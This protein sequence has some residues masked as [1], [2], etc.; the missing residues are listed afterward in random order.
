MFNK[1]T[2]QQKALK[3]EAPADV[4]AALQLPKGTTIGVVFFHLLE[5]RGT[6]QPIT[7]ASND[8]RLRS[9][10]EQAKVYLTPEDRTYLE[11]AGLL[12]RMQGFERWTEAQTR[13]NTRVAGD[14]RAKLFEGIPSG[15]AL[16]LYAP[17]E[18]LAAA[19]ERLEGT[20]GISER[21]RDAVS[22][23]AGAME[24]ERKKLN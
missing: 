15:N 12:A 6:D 1:Q 10:L 17:G 21:V 18:L 7:V 5:Q 11:K 3:T 20:T 23:L 13:A 14:V 16:L 4:L 9:I 22:E 19:M 8:D 2:D 24:A